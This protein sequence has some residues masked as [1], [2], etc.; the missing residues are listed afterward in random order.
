MNPPRD[1]AL[2]RGV[3][4]PYEGFAA[5]IPQGTGREKRPIGGGRLVFI[6]NEFPS[7]IRHGT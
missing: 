3:P 2:L 4:A 7:G 5:G 1:A 6:F